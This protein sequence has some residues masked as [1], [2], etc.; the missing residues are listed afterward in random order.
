[1]TENDLGIL[2]SLATFIKFQSNSVEFDIGD[3]D[4]TEE[5]AQYG[6]RHTLDK[7]IRAA[8]QARDLIPS[9]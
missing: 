7:I 3:F 1:M 5:D 2:K 4:M 8:T 9:T 6:V